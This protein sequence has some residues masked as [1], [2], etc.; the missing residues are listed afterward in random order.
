MD[1]FRDLVGTTNQIGGFDY[2]TNSSSN[3]MVLIRHN[4]GGGTTRSRNHRPSGLYELRE[5]QS[6]DGKIAYAWQYYVLDANNV[7]VSAT[8][9]GQGFNSFKE[10]E[11]AFANDWKIIWRL[12]GIV[13]EPNA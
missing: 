6:P 9:P 12:V 3:P 5:S 7:R 10:A 4:Y 2:L 1:E 8:T 13:R 11:F